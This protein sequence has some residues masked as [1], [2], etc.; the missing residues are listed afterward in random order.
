MQC[1]LFVQGSP[2]RY[3]SMTISEAQNNLIGNTKPAQQD[4]VCMNWRRCA[5]INSDVQCH[6]DFAFV[7]C[8]RARY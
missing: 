5:D 8:R 7:C 1:V 6:P 3:P 4:C 2:Q